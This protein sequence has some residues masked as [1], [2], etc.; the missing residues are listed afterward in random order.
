MSAA[1]RYAVV[2]GGA[3]GIGWAIAQ[4]LREAGREVVLADVDAER[5]RE[6]CAGDAGLDSLALDVADGAAVARAFAALEVERGPLGLLVNNAGIRSQGTLDALEDEEWAR[7]LGVNLGGA[8][9]C[10]K[11]AGRQLLA[12]GGGAIVNVVSVAAERGVPARGAYAAAKAGLVSLTRTA[13]VEWGGR[14]VRVN[15]VGPG[16]VET[17]LLRGAIERGQLDEAAILARVPSGRIGTPA[18]M[19]AAVC[20]LASDAASY[21]NGQTLWVD[22]AFLVDYGV[23]AR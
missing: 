8:F 13:A 16:Y 11:A 4:A 12:A 7:V 3:D 21:V 1:E 14:G 2:T 5:A 10:L 6:R 23:G 18:E 9:H 15:A 20:F 17:S 19:A 22:G